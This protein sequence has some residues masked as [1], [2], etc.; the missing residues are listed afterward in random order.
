MTPP[1]ALRLAD[2]LVVEAADG[3]IAARE[4]TQLGRQRVEVV[5]HHRAERRA[6]DDAPVFADLRSHFASARTCAKLVSDSSELPTKA[7][8]VEQRVA[9]HRKIEV[10]RCL[11]RQQPFG[12]QQ[13]SCRWLARRFR[14]R[15]AR[16][17]KPS[18]RVNPFQRSTTSVAARRAMRDRLVSVSSSR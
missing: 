15:R 10:V 5:D 13:A 3:A 1:S 8:A 17:C 9:A 6:Q 16:Y 11:A 12:V 7:Q 2:L 4:E 18:V 14:S